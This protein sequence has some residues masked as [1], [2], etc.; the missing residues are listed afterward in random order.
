MHGRCALTLNLHTL[1]TSHSEPGKSPRTLTRREP[2]LQAL[3]LTLPPPVCDTWQVLSDP[4]RRRQYD[5]EGPSSLNA[6]PLLDPSVVFSFIF[7]EDKFR[8]L[9]GDLA[10]AL[11][12]GK[13]AKSPAA[14]LEIADGLLECGCERIVVGGGAGFTCG[15]GHA[16]GGFGVFRTTRFDVHIPPERQEFVFD[17]A[18]AF[19]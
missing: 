7:G 18:D 8:H 11:T 12:R 6:H 3:T 2:S 19:S 5:S 13:A 1:H 9:V 4:A 15:D 16:S 17:A 10:V 14:L